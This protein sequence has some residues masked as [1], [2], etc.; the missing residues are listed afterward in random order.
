MKNSS[1][2]CTKTPPHTYTVHTALSLI[3]TEHAKTREPILFSW[4]TFQS[5]QHNIQLQL[6]DL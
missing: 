4:Y 3:V 6:L 5:I 2:Y 1:V